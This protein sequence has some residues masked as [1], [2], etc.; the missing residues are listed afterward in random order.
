MAGQSA[1]MDTD[2]LPGLRPLFRYQFLHLTSYHFGG[3]WNSFS[4]GRCHIG[5][6]DRP[7]APLVPEYFSANQFSVCRINT[8]MESYHCISPTASSRRSPRH[9]RGG[10]PCGQ[11][12]L[13]HRA[14]PANRVNLKPPPALSRSSAPSTATACEMLRI[15]EIN[16]DCPAVDLR[17]DRSG[18]REKL[19]NFFDF[20]LVAVVSA[21]GLSTS[22]CTSAARTPVDRDSFPYPPNATDYQRTRTTGPLRRPPLWELAEQPAGQGN[23]DKDQEVFCGYQPRTVPPVNR[24]EQPLPEVEVQYFPSN[25]G[26]TS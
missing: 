2:F 9:R 12:G 7:F 22:L 13:R 5:P 21:G 23:P 10:R 4:G 25:P 14:A 20:G 15:C 16:P 24:E 17:Q 3:F 11:G 1:S 8:A 26:A 19:T 18:S 6:A